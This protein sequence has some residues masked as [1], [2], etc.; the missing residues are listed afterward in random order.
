MQ[1]HEDEFAGMMRALDE[2]R[3]RPVPLLARLRTWLAWLMVRLLAT[4]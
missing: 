3:T 2:L 1:E 4:R